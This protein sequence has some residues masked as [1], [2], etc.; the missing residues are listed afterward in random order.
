MKIFFLFTLLTTSALVA[1]QQNDRLVIWAHGQ[2]GH[3]NSNANSEETWQVYDDIFS[4]ERRMVSLRNNWQ[5]RNGLGNYGSEIGNDLP[6]P[7]SLNPE[8]LPLGIGHSNGG[9][10]LRSLDQQLPGG[11]RQLGGVVT[12]GT[13]HRG[14]A[15][16]NSIQSGSMASAIARGCRAL[17]AGPSTHVGQS[18]PIPGNIVVQGITTAALCNALSSVIDEFGLEGS[19]ESLSAQ[20]AAVG[21]NFIAALNQGT[22][23][24]NII[25]VWGNEESPVHWRLVSSLESDNEDDQRYQHIANIV[26]GL[27]IGASAYYGVSASINVIGGILSMNPFSIIKGGYNVYQSVQYS[28]GAIWLANS[29]QYWLDEIECSSSQ[30]F[31]QTFTYTYFPCTDFITGT[32]EW[33]QCMEENG[34]LDDVGGG[35]IA[36]C[37]RQF[38][39]VRRTTVNEASDGFFCAT[40]QI[41]DPF[42]QNRTYEA[43]GVNHSDETN[44]TF[45]QTRN[46]NDEMQEEL[47]NIFDRGD[48]FRIPGV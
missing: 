31:T 28:R 40:T 7:T 34:C 47:N 8:D 33:L 23:N 16:I 15:V 21:S 20:Q 3:A 13:P 17:S 41:F 46:G 32:A 19:V 48:E 22:Q 9:L 45:M 42:D 18:L 10:A 29:E 6:P 44:T 1:A 35:G 39:G 30:T 24:S 4:Q 14:G 12:V 38:T 37:A 26:R 27:Y 43:E 5:E 11:N 2:G 36:G 25:S